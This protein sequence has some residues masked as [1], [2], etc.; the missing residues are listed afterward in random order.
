MATGCFS[1]VEIGT[2][3]DG[4]VIGDRV[5]AFLRHCE[6]LGAAIFVHP[7]RPVGL[8]RNWSDRRRSRSSS[9][10]RARQRRCRIAD[11]RRHSRR[12]PRLRHRRS[13]TGRAAS[14]LT[15][16]RLAAGW[17]HLGL[18]HQRSPWEQARS[19]FYDTLVYDTATL[20]HL[21]DAF[22]HAA[23]PRHGPSR[24]CIQIAQPY[25]ACRPAR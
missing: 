24:S 8:D 13:A 6:R 1:G 22:G 21:I 5:R 14:R 7:L 25:A 17:E 23:L 19:L 3:V 2:N 16:P 10:S 11:H 20:R 9:R 4:V 12:H 18:N 15:L